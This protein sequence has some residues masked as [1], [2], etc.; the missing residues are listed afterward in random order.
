MRRG[1]TLIELLVVITIILVVSLL[2]LP[3][4]IPAL[5]HRQVS[6]AARVVQGSLVGARDSALR[7]NTPSGIRL[8]PD[9]AFPLK[10]LS[11]GQIDP[12]QPLAANRII[13]IAAAPNYTDGRISRVDTATLPAN[14]MP[15]PALMVCEQVV[16]PNGEINNPTSWFWN[17]RVG[18]KI[19][20]NN[21]GPWYTVIGPMVWTAAQGNS[22]LFVNVGSPGTQ[23]PFSQT[24]GGAAVRPE[25]LW[26]VNGRDDNG[27]GYVDEGFDGLD[28]D[29]KNGVD[30][31]GEWEQ[32]KW[33]D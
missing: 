19:Q 5:S 16:G 23:S 30:D 17:I 11:N 4:I 2:A 20:V 6:E 27:N 9:P 26:L 33:L 12:S 21:T 8:L 7:D 13:P 28:N 10:Y 29:N 14:F 18:D 32:E 25:F 1:F 15:Y 22:E 31:L 24:Q 3:V